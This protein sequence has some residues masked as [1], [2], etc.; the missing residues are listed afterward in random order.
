MVD[1]VKKV[2][3]FN[4]LKFKAWIGIS[5]LCTLPLLIIG[6]YSFETLGNISKDI[7]IESNIQAF[8]QVKYEVNQYITTYNELI[9]LLAYDERFKKAELYDSAVEAMKYLD[10]SYENINRIIW[11]D[12][13]GN[14]KA[15]SQKKTEFS[16]SFQEEALAKSNL[17]F[18]FTQE[19]CLIKEKMTSAPDS[20]AIIA[21]IS[22][23]KLR[24]SLE[25]LT[26]G[27]NFKYYLITENGENILEQPDFP[28]D[29]IA[30]LLNHPCGA[31]DLFP[32]NSDSSPKIVVSL[33]ILKY[34]LKIFVFQ[35]AGDVYSVARKISKKTLNFILLLVI[36][37][38]V[39]AIYLGWS[40]TTPITVIADNALKLSEGKQNVRVDIDREDELGFLAKCF[41]SM[42]Q[43]INH[44]IKEINALY[45]V[46]NFINASSDNKK[47]LDSCLEYI[48]DIFDANRGSIMLINH[49]RMSLVVESY[50]LSSK[51]A[52]NTLEKTDNNLENNKKELSKEETNND[53]F[54]IKIGEGIAGEVVS[55]GKAI[56]CMNCLKDERFKSYNED[57]FKTPKTLLSVPLR[58]QNKVIGVIN[59]SD[60]LDGL[61]FS[62]DDLALL[63]A[64]ADQMAMSID[65]ARLHNLSLINENTGLYIRKFLDLRLEDEIKRSK[66]F[67]FPLTIAMFSVDS[68]SKIIN[69]K[70]EQ[71]SDI[72]LIN[73][74]KLLKQTVRATDIATEYDPTKYCV[75]LAHTTEEQAKMFADRFIDTIKNHSI[76]IDNQ[77]IKVTLSAG[78]C[79]YSKDYGNYKLLLAKAN[80]ALSE[81]SKIGNM[82]YIYMAT[83]K[84][85]E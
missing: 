39:L 48:I 50:K 14:L 7:L 3:F 46:T 69:E 41:N 23:F 80:E 10:R 70:G 65:N 77:E 53:L 49:E 13:K 8:Q 28:Q 36:T 78:I 15:H 42:S 76:M 54:E 73:I 51:S 9:R 34:G 64:I 47:A 45:K 18:M 38:L 84:G 85:A 20:D 81:S 27:S 67:G 25:A 68:L 72:I 61:S 43:K 74:G 37:S 16:M 66:R 5:I 44:K 83:P 57:K 40:I 19:A 22:F 71:T 12:S 62:K 24:K 4:S 52:E 60:K 82:S 32:E 26:L 2:S 31:Y 79:Q 1:I 11:I 55:T 17:S 30:D 56:L 33:P 75:I 63:Q 59:L 35:D 58:L 6:G 29:I 21:T